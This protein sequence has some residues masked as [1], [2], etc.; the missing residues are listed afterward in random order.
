MSADAA[1]LLSEGFLTIPDAA[2]QVRA[3][4]GDPVSGAGGRA[5]AVTL[6]NGLS[7]EVLPDRGLDLG[8][9][10]F[11]GRPMAWRAP[12]N[13]PGPEPQALDWLGRFNGG[14]LLTCGLDNTGPARDGYGLHG[15][16][17]HT[18]AADVVVERL[19]AAD[20]QGPGVRF[21]GTI[22]S[23]EIFGRHVRAYRTITARTDSAA[24]EISDRIVNEGWQDAPV[25]LLYHVNFG[26][27]LVLPG[28]TVE[29]DATEH[30]V[31]AH[32]P[33]I[34]DWTV[35]PEPIE[36][37]TES[38][39]EH[40]GF[41]TDADGRATAT[42]TSPDGVRARVRWRTAELPRLIQWVL[43]ARGAWALGIEPGNGPIYGPGWEDRS[44]I[45]VLAAKAELLTDLRIAFDRP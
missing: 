24:I 33:Q 22:D 3:L 26:A 29:V 6:L 28:T 4:A 19:P 31:K 40:S 30:P 36:E 8:A 10:W 37:L 23:V 38:V 21:R 27:P 42:I 7:F 12:L 14:L 41:A 5:Y 1:A 45:P 17:H 35:Y 44:E 39:W 9:V 32:V 18:R 16:W 13:S 25:A 20:G 11:D 15:S 43:P 2:V 34:P